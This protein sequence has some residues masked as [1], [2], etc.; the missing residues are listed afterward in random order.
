MK[1]IIKIFFVLILMLV[2]SSCSKHSSSNDKDS[3][4]CTGPY[5]YVNSATSDA[6]GGIYILISREIGNGY[7]ELIIYNSLDYLSSENFVIEIN[8]EQSDLTQNVDFTSFGAQLKAEYRILIE[9]DVDGSRQQMILKDW[10]KNYE[11]VE[12]NV[13]DKLADLHI[14][15]IYN[16]QII[17]QFKKDSKYITYLPIKSLFLKT[18]SNDKISVDNIGTFSKKEILKMMSLT[19]DG[20]DTSCDD[21]VEKM[22]Y[23]KLQSGVFPIQYW[24]T[25]AEKRVYRAYKYLNNC[26]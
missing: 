25:N 23:G 21:A 24:R 18:N 12:I 3:Q 22:R 13:S 26:D 15:K 17:I 4:P 14:Y 16:A 10:S 9:H 8:F 5:E 19:S 11:P 7:N 1:K 2:T 6:R 20:N